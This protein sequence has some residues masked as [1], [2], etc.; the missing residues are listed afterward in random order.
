MASPDEELWSLETS[1]L[2]QFD[3]RVA[4][5]ARA[6]SKRIVALLLAKA[7]TNDANF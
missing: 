3:F 1:G 2:S 7:A 6:W 5:L 4:T